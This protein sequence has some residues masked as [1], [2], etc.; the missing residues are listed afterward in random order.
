MASIQGE[1]ATRDLAQGA[2]NALEAAGV[3]RDQIRIW[4]IIPESTPARPSGGA[5]TAGALTGAYLGGVG[6]LLLGAAVGSAVGSA[7][8]PA[9]SLPSASGVRLVVS[10]APSGVDVAALLRQHGAVNVG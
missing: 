9:A 1:F 5:T 4:N 10:S 7:T 3:P 2:L 8:A 6:G